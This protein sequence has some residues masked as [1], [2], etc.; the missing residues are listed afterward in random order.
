MVA[1]L[2]EEITSYQEIITIKD[3]VV[4]GLTHQ[5]EEL[6]KQHSHL[7]EQCNQ[8]NQDNQ[9]QQ[10]HQ[11]QSLHGQQASHQGQ[12]QGLQQDE[13]DQLSKEN[14]IETYQ[15]QTTE[16]LTSVTSSETSK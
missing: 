8:Q 5:L 14:G 7:L 3:N 15:Q 9:S 11:E 16:N 12:E 10:D 6:Q 2:Q 13:A 1:K 4:V